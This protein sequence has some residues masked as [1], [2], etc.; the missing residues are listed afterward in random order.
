MH[1]ARVGLYLTLRGMLK[2]KPGSF[3]NDN[4]R[5][6]QQGEL[7][8]TLNRFAT[9]KLLALLLAT[10]AHAITIKAPDLAQNGAV[11]PVE[12]NLDKPLTAGQR[13]DL[14]V[15]GE[16]AAQVKVVEGKLTAFSTRVKG[17]RNNTTIAAR[18]VVNGSEL[19]SASRNTK[20]TITAPVGGSP[21]AVG[22]MKVRA[23]SGDLKVLMTSE[24]GFAGTL[25]LKDT[26]LR[27]EISGSSVMAKNPLVSVRG[28]FSDQVTAAIDGKT[29]KIASPS[30]SAAPAVV[31]AH[32]SANGSSAIHKSANG[33]W[34]AGVEPGNLYVIKYVHTV[35]HKGESA[36]D[37]SDGTLLVA[38]KTRGEAVAVVEKV[39]AEWKVNE[40]YRRAAT[41]DLIVNVLG[42]CTGPNWGALLTY[43]S[44]MTTTHGWSCGTP[45]PRKAIQ[46]AAEKCTS[47]K[48]CT[49]TGTDS[50]RIII[51]HSGA[52][53]WTAP[54]IEQS[55]PPHEASFPAL[56]ATIVQ[57]GFG[58]TGFAKSPQDAINLFGKTCGGGAGRRD[59]HSC[60][61]TSNNIKCILTVKDDPRDH[62]HNQQKCVDTKLTAEGYLP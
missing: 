48:S 35:R 30:R 5:Q 2:K 24:N 22:D 18:V 31:A 16:L 14:L 23:Q 21:T 9:L 61:V 38:A 1:H 57:H 3:N 44:G 4:G 6:R 51:G 34:P 53:S 26:G 36:S 55:F 52:R 46:A 50:L 42:E 58:G 49:V 45:T 19:D 54:N 33:K 13:L 37:K 7:L 8:K 11:I 43:S 39:W 56:A 41:T 17:S 15:N 29:P 25:V 27:A 28:N 62:L 12:I 47:N 59:T 32:A 20:V 10:P 60:W 40:H